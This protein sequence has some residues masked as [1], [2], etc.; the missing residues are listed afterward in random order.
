MDLTF[1]ATRPMSVERT[2]VDTNVLLYSIDEK[3]LRK[4]DIAREIIAGL[5]R[6][7]NGHIS[8][9]VVNE[10]AS[11]LVRKFGRSPSDARKLC[12]DLSDFRLEVGSMAQVQ[13]A[14]R[15]MEVA[16]IS[17]WDACIVS[18]AVLSGC[19]IVMTEDMFSD[20][21]IKGTKII[22]PFRIA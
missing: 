4:R 1:H 20:Q 3:D 7:G 13:E 2:F 22:N 21:R 10:F 8:M 16:S 12:A 14:L 9:Q 18:S 17:Y 6:N 11:N 5:C 15:I 19:R